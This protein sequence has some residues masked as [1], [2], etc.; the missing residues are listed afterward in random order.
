MLP[1][2]SNPIRAYMQPMVLVK[3]TKAIVNYEE[4]E[5]RTEIVTR[6]VRQPL[7]PQELEILQRGQR[8]WKWECLHLLPNVDLKPDDIVLYKNIRY[9]V[10]EKYD[11]TEYGYIEYLICQDFEDDEIESS[12][13]SESI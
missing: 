1:N 11:C 12:E 10:K 5:V 3:V 8:A 13:S 4:T 7:P 6:G 2:L 9:R